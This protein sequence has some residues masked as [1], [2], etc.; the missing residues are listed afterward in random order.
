MSDAHNDT[1]EI[2]PR[3]VDAIARRAAVLVALI[4]R[5]AFESPDADEGENDAFTLET[6]R[7]D[8]YSWVRREAATAMTE[9][10]RSLLATPAGD[11][12]EESVDECLLAT[13]PARA[14]AWSLRALDALS[15]SDSPELHADTLTGWAPEPWNEVGRWMR[16]LVPR[17]EAALAEERERWELWHW[18]AT[19]TRDHVEPGEDLASVV[20][21]VAREAS[22]S[23]LIVSTQ[24]DF[25]VDGKPFGSIPTDRRET[26]ALLAQ[27]YLHA[28][29]WICG[30]GDTWD[31][32]PLYPD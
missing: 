2:E 18:R 1:I 13:V 25:A 31:D 20:A 16:K 7:F 30:F 32:V 19:L 29:D 24:D 14:L 11:L 17:P 4:R 6:D 26:V 9:R 15:P 23:G 28:L 21:D 27:G 5:A 12:D 8:L 22:N 10:E 3:Q